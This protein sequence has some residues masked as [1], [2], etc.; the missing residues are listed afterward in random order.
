MDLKSAWKSALIRFLLDNLG[1]LVQDEVDAWLD[2]AFD[3][4][5]LL[6]PALRN[7]AP[8]RDTVLRELYQISPSEVFDRWRVEH[9]E[10]LF[11]D[12]D[13]VIVR[14]GKEL[15][16]VRSIVLSFGAPDQSQ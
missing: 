13:V 5:P 7:L 1:R 15:L 14:I 16:A 11:P 3:I 8:Y 2:N 12:T 4:A 10:I 6:E 9:P